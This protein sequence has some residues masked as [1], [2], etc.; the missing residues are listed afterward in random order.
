MSETPVVDKGP[1]ELERQTFTYPGDDYDY[2]VGPG[3]DNSN[4]HE[5]PESCIGVQEMN[6]A[7]S[8]GRASL[9]PLVR[10]LVEAVNH[11]LMP[12]GCTLDDADYHE[13]DSFCSCEEC[14]ISSGCQE[15]KDKA[16]FIDL[17]AKAKKELGE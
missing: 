7:Y 10:E 5:V 11:N 2:V 6:L 15:K 8:E 4:R 14:K 9:L 13:S 3:I 16:R 12:D 1:Y 17:L